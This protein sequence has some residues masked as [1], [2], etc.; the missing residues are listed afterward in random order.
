MYLFDI[1]GSEDQVH[2]AQSKL[3]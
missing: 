1:V 2:T 3:C